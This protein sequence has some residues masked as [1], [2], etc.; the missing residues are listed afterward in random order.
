MPETKFQFLGSQIR[1]A[2]KR[3]NLTQQKL[4]DKT[5]LAIK[6]VQETEKGKK[7]ATYDTLS[8]LIDCLGVS[9]DTLFPTKTPIS[10]EK[11]QN[12]IRKVQLCNEKNQEILL[13]TI[14]FLAD[15]LLSE[16][17]NADSD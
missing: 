3:K 1:T 2:R 5:G 8:R 15:Q 14:N 9:A 12:L 13:N 6:T 17:E 10:D 16:Q 7:N 11:L 4:A